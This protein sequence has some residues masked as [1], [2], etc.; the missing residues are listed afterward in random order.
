MNIKQRGFTLLLATLVAS[1][2]LTVAAS[3]FSIAKKQA[4]LASLSQQSQYAFYAADTA[5]ECALFWDS[6]YN[7]FA[8]T[9][10]SATL[11]STTPTSPQCDGSSFTLL[12]SSPYTNANPA[13]YPFTRGIQLQIAQPSGN[14]FCANVAIIK[15][16]GTISAGGACTSV[17]GD[18]IRTQIRA[19]GFNTSCATIASNP[20]ALQRSVELNY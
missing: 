5:A 6:Q 4:E 1:I 11:P 10:P 3:I 7:Y 8:S 13:S 19:Y 15:C 20:V 2:V 12:N 9:T 18:P 14:M 17:A 16:Q